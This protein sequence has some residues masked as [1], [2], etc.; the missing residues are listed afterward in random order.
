[1]RRFAFSLCA[2][3]LLTPSAALAVPQN[4]SLA[5][6][7]KPAVTGV[8]PE[9]ASYWTRLSVCAALTGVRTAHCYPGHW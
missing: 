5:A 6:F 2:L 7:R 9:A 4:H 1:M 8:R 3:A